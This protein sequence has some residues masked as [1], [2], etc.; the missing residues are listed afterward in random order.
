MFRRLILPFFFILPSFLFAQNSGNNS[1]NYADI[2]Q[3]LEKEKISMVAVQMEVI[4]GNYEQ[5]KKMI[6][7]YIAQNKLDESEI[8]E[9]HSLKDIL[10]RISID[11]SKTKK[12]VIDYIKKY[13]PGVTDEML[14]QWE[15]SRALESMII[16]GEKK[17]FNRAAP[18]L[19]RLDEN[20][21]KK[22]DE[23]DGI[24]LDREDKVLKTHL[25]AILKE[26]KGTEDIQAQP[27]KMKVK[28]SVT[29]KP[30][31]V[32]EGEIVRCWL[33]YPREDNRRQSDVKLL[34]ASETNYIISPVDYK[35]RTIYMQRVV[36]KDKP[37]TFSIEFTYQSVAEW[38][39]LIG[40]EISPYDVTSDLYKE[41]TKERIPHIIF[42][43]RIKN[44]STQIVGKETNPYLKV[45]KI[46]EWVNQF[47]WAGAREYSTIPNIPEYV[48]DNSHGDCG[49]VGLLFIT[50]TRC[51]GIPARW[52]S[53]FMMHPGGLN[54]HD[55]AE[56][57]FENIGWVP[58]D[59]SF[60]RKNME[61]EDDDMRFFFSNGIDSYRWIVND[62]YSQPL[63]PL[64][65]YPRSETVDFQRGELEWKGGN[66]YFNNWTWN[67]DVEYLD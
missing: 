52:Q 41:Y 26:L 18:N 10:D 14:L 42:S 39:N 48:L 9:L 15:E 38:F 19:F 5:A 50:L 53:G 63:Y 40:K 29:L 20:A 60:G 66:I 32:P 55:W 7:L 62:D 13:Y 59:Q 58:V 1:R 36:E 12:D 16:N 57:Y 22:K 64:K 17:Y 45:R 33:P 61:S 8:Y 44:L 3:S 37:L 28:Y 35:H 56:V 34:S 67:I 30:N 65:T 21:K 46:F 54:L 6:D 47:P 24:A 51:S 27:V 31:V 25:P 11:F 49:Q 23:I 43:E 4:E 2:S